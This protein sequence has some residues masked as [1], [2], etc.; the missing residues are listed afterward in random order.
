MAI[1][2]EQMK[3]INLL[4]FCLLTYSL[5]FSQH[6]CG[7]DNMHNQR[8][9]NDPLYAKKVEE[10]EVLIRKYVMAHPESGVSAR[11]NETVYTIPVV[12]HVIHTGGDVGSIYNP[13]DAQ[14]FNAITYMNDVY[15]GTPGWVG[16]ALGAKDIGIRFVMAKRDPNCNP[17]N[18]IV[19]VNASQNA[20]YVQNGISSSFS[21]PGVA[22]ATV[23]SLSRWNP[24]N[25]YNIW[26]VN[27]INGKDGTSGQ[28]VAG[29]A[30]FP[31]TDANLDGT[32][33]L[34]TAMRDDNKILTHELGHAFNLYHPFQGSSN[35]T[36]CPSSLNCGT[37]GDRVCDTDPVSYNVDTSGDVDFSCRTGLNTCS[38]N[39]YSELT[40]SNFMNY[41]NCFTLFSPG[42]KTRMRA[43]M[44]L[45]SR[46]SLA[47][48]LGGIPPNQA[49]VCPPKVD[50]NS[51]SATIN[52]S[53]DIIT[54][55][56]GYKDYTFSLSV[57]S[58][59]ES[60]SVITL[61]G[62]GSTATGGVD[63]QIFTQGNTTTP[64]N[65]I[66][67]P[68]GSNTSQNFVVRLWDDDDVEGDENIV[69]NFSVNSGGAVKGNLNPTLN[70][71]IAD[72]DAAAVVPNSTVPFAV[73][74]YNT[75][76]GSESTPFRGQKAKN[77]VQSL[78]LASELLQAGLQPNQQITGLSLQVI[79]KKSTTAYSGFTVSLGTTSLTSLS[80]G[81]RT[82]SQVFT[83]TVTTT[84][85]ENRINFTTP[86]TWNGTSNLAVQFCY[87]NVT[88]SANDIIQG[89]SNAISET[90]IATC[91]SDFTTGT[92][93]G[94]ALTRVLNTSSRPVI[95]F[96][97]T[98]PGNAVNSSL[99]S[100]EAYL[101]PNADVYFFNTNKE[102]I[103][104]IK[105]LTSFDYG[106]TKVE[107]DRSGTGAAA[108]WSSTPANQLSQKTF[109]V[110][111]QNPNPS[112][113]YQIDLYY[114]NAEKQGYEST[115]GQL[116]STVQMVKSEGAIAG[117]T[118]SNQLI[119]SV[120]VN[121]AANKSTYG[122]EHIVSATFNNGF[123][124]FAVGSPG[125]ATSVNDIQVLEG[126]K[127]YPN[128]VTKQINIGFEQP[129]RNVSVRMMS[130]DGR[131][132]YTQRFN[133]VI[134]NH[135]IMV[136]KFEKGLYL[137]EINSDEGKK[138]VS[139]IKQ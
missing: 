52:E 4:L 93:A 117:I 35:K 134:Q 85:G 122:T 88:G 22:E 20:E 46:V 79:S 123:S 103:A 120:T 131:V 54:G 55:C 127:V 23:K 31:D 66:I 74:N 18:G 12:V 38:G 125:V 58:A 40:E 64:S 106:C 81:F 59:P 13:T 44:S 7:F 69:L 89:Q 96:F 68:A 41:T 108:F 1:K 45:A 33:A 107:V 56:T 49:P 121:N 111:P 82:V 98:T 19:R 113:S 90:T 57:A 137:I 70:I 9:K 100:S 104:R 43:A 50:F 78:F 75:D 16:G 97:S 15:S 10:N 101:G 95:K 116:W 2:N 124:G 30:Y 8:L 6:L 136:D 72:N 115:T 39:D 36:Q 60:E 112:G 24:D 129:Q 138:T 28:Y 128:P 26:V 48:S 94:C 51:A 130:V 99:V 92:T 3:K 37:T 84:A 87:D 132:L 126:V 91:M 139:I 135:F 61:S 71:R 25:Y 63:Y 29:F 83:G 77:R 34:A 42:Q 105:N 118:P 76:L 5:S 86:F 17:T 67:F 11:M 110:T 32:V 65:T 27:K 114:S 14:I 119:S 102:I 133:G 21:S 73:G 80:N 62:A 109:K 53:T 47:N